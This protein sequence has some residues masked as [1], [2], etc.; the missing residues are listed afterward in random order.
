MGVDHTI[1]YIGDVAVMRLRTNVRLE[2][3]LEI[4]SGVAATISTNRRM[5]VAGNHFIYSADEISQIAEHGRHLWTANARVAYVASDSLSLNLLRT[6]EIYREQENYETRV[7]DNEA[8]ALEWL[9][10]W[11][12]K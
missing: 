3:M 8:A 9:Q 4:L 10:A 11:D 7:F 2:R 5:W 6:F 12:G 1:E